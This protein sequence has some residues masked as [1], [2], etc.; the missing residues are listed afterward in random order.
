MLEIEEHIQLFP[1][2]IAE[3]LCFVKINHDG[4]ADCK[5][6]VMIQHLAAQFPQNRMIPFLALVVF[7]APY[8]AA[9][10]SVIKA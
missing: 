3:E 7:N 8:S 5:T 6:V 1:P 2:G 10:F 4:F 9:L